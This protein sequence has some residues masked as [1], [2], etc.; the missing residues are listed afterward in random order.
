MGKK[1]YGEE[2]VNERLIKLEQE[3]SRLTNEI[4]QLNIKKKNKE[5]NNKRKIEIGD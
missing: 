5:C 3:V 4:K 1:G 2:S